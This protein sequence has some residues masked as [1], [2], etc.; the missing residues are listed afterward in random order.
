MNPLT[1]KLIALAFSLLILANAYI[2]RRVVGTW[3]FPGCIFALFWFGYTFLPLTVLFSEPVNPWPVAY[4]FVATVA[5]SLSGVCYFRW[6]TAF[7]LNRRKGTAAQYFDTTF[8]RGTFYLASGV[9][10]VCFVLNMRTQGFSIEDML[11]RSVDTAALYASRRG[12]DALVLGLVS[13]LGMAMAYLAATIGGLLFGCSTSKRNSL[14]VL[15]GAFL[16]SIASLLFE[17]AKG[18][19]FQFISLFFGCVLVTRLFEGKLYLIDRAGIRSGILALM[20]LVPLTIV[21]FLSRG[22]YGVEDS[23]IVAEMLPGYLA[24]Y[25]FGY[26]YAFSDWFSFQVGWPASMSYA[27]EAS[28][29]GFF[30]FASA[31][32]A[33]GSTRSFAPGVYDEYFTSGLLTGNIYTMFRGLII[34][35]GILGSLLYMFISGFAIHLS[36]YFLLVRRRPTVT[37]VTFIY[38]MGYFYSSAIVS[39]FIYNVIPASIVL[40]SACLEVNSRLT[41]WWKRGAWGELR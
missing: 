10:L 20:V 23:S 24:S 15:L 11:L 8:L 29:Y 28:S 17:S 41:S 9:S 27:H 3:L 25:A 30:T 12:S 32:R 16:P 6:P 37:V 2:V 33:F 26:L 7:E 5:F 4:L 34:D 31:F 22:I 18:L 14:L 19:L 35:F 21:S 38:V 39:L 13:K 1:G 36:F 40:L